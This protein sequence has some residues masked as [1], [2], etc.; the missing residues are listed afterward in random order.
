MQLQPYSLGI[1]DRFGRQGLAQL[2]ALR[3]AQADGVAITPVW[4]KS[5]REHQ[6]LGTTPADTRRAA[7]QAVRAAAWSGTYFVD[8]D[9]VNLDNVEAFLEECDFFTL[10][11]AEC[12]GR[13]PDS[14]DLA[15]FAKK[16][17]PLLG[18][19]AIP[20]LDRPLEITEQRL[21]HF[22]RSYLAAVHAA[23]RLYRKIA[24]QKGVGDFVVEVSLDEGAVPQSP[25]ELLLI[26]SALA[27]EGVPVETIAP[28][29]TGQ[30]LKGV[31]YCG[32]VEQFA[33]EFQDYLA[34]LRYAR[35]QF[36][37][38]GSL[39]LSIHSGSD[40]FSLYPIIHR[41]L[42]QLNAAIHL[43]TAGTTWLAELTGLAL[44]GG[45]GLALAKDVYALALTRREE[46]CRP[47]AAVV[48]ID[49]QRLPT[50]AVVRG[51]NSERFAATLRH[52]QHCAQYN[53]HF[54]QLLHVAYKIAAEMG[55]RYLSALATYE[56]IIAK[57]VTE[58]LWQRH[59]RPLFL[60]T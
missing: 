48:A 38:P 19:L 23:A 12:I 11:V 53:P 30:F 55:E 50:V 24:A 20:G 43:K 22:G 51:W 29:F 45:E 9:H 35:A 10:D 13:S 33:R 21:E 25:L 3:S 54:R 47:Y 5:H 4:N 27:A 6:L 7:N 17:R 31:D 32:D 8:A 16:Q 15:A 2:A 44:A 46:L 36:G 41:A 40:K 56:S 26:L 57:Q 14:S 58:N 42:K 28:K 1:G 60:G 39:K 52:D 49:A 34:V 59:I 18:K 37:L